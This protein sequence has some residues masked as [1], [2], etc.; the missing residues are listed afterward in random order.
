MAII[1]ASAIRLAMGAK[2]CGLRLASWWRRRMVFLFDGQIAGK[3][4]KW[5]VDRCSNILMPSLVTLKRS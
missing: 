2:W 4:V 5:M 3:G 1:V